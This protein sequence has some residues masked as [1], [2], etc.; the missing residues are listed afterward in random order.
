MLRKYAQSL[1]RT[2]IP[3]SSTLTT[4]FV[5]EGGDPRMS[6]NTV[7]RHIHFDCSDFSDLSFSFSA[8]SMSLDELASSGSPSSELAFFIENQY[9]RSGQPMICAIANCED[10]VETVTLFFVQDKRLL[11]GCCQMHHDQFR[12]PSKASIPS[13]VLKD[14]HRY[15]SI[16]LF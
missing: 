5:G 10:N 16:V 14:N 8:Q 12:S 9:W 2:L 3:L 1:P 7:D 11:R 4:F 13:E 15:I 6:R